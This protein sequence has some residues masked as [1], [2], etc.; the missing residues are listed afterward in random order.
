MTNNFAS[1][2]YFENAVAKGSMAKPQPRSP[3]RAS[4][5]ATAASPA[6]TAA[7]AKPPKKPKRARRLCEAEACLSGAA[8]GGIPGRCKRHGGGRRCAEGGCDS[9]L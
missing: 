2:P 8:G 9:S 3:A 5:H 6:S 4:G 1:K 7:A